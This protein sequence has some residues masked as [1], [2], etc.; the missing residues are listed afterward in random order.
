MSNKKGE[1]YRYSVY[2]FLDYRGNI[3]YIGKS[4]NLRQRISYHFSRGHLPK[5]CYEQVAR[6]EYMELLSRAEMDIYEIYLINK[7][8]PYYN[9]RD[10]R[11]DDFSFYLPEKRWNKFNRSGLDNNVEEIPLTVEDELE[12][13]QGKLYMADSEINRTTTRINN[14]YLKYLEMH[15]DKIG[16]DDD[17][18]SKMKEYINRIELELAYLRHYGDKEKQNKIRDEFHS[19]L[20]A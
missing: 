11:G 8:T 4:I 10:N 7:L 13:T 14:Y 12:I 9:I 6:V 17:I 1:K 3:L 2:R 19:N 15:I 20:T 18:K 16:I 5:E